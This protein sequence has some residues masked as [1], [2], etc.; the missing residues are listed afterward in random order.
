MSDRIGKTDF[1]KTTE[2]RRNDKTSFKHD[3]HK[4]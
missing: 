2:S 4:K 1:T 3:F